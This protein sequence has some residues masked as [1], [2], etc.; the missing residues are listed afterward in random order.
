MPL[1]ASLMKEREIFAYVAL[2][3]SIVHALGPAGLVARRLRRFTSRSHKKVDEL[4]IEEAFPVVP[5]KP[6]ITQQH[7][8][9]GAMVVEEDG[10]VAHNPGLFPRRVF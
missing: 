5:L 1:L 9:R 7:A 2:Q 3:L 8:E 6:V 10:L 4:T